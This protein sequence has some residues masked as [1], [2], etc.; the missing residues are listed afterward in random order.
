[1]VIAV[2]AS[3]WGFGAIL[4][5]DGVVCKFLYDIPAGPEIELLQIQVGESSSQQ[6]MESLAA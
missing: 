5:I 3:T 4:T 2:D 1:V 6:S